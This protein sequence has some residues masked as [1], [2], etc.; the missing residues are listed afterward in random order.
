MK[1]TKNQ[2]HNLIEFLNRTTLQGKEAVTL[3]NLLYE[4]AR[5]EEIE[6]KG[7]DGILTKKV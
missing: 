2:K 4:I 6:E 1:M 5:A 3:V 7:E